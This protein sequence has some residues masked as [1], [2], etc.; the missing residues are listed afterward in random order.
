MSAPA[1]DAGARRSKMGL[2]ELNLADEARFVVLLGWVVEG[3][4]W[5]AQRGAPSGPFS[6]HEELHAA[7]SDAL[8]AAGAPAQL[9]VLRAHPSPT[10][11]PI[12]ASSS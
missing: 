9:G 4:A 7:F 1:P 10:C 11:P 2:A 12:S 5:V 3:S 6:N 8:S